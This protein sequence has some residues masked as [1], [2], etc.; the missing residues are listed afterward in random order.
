MGAWILE[1]WE[2]GDALYNKGIATGPGS[3]EE[4]IL[5]NIP[6]S[7]ISLACDFVALSTTGFLATNALNVL[8]Y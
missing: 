5:I 8:E 4:F 1:T 6:L 3:P 7:G 2:I